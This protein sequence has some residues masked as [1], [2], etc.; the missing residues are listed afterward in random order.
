MLAL[1]EIV[2]GALHR[3]RLAEIVVESARKGCVAAFQIGEYTV[4]PP[5]PG[6]VEAALRGLLVIQSLIYH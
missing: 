6:A 5:G 3:V 1:A 4:P 2:V